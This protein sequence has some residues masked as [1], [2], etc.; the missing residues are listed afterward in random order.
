[1]VNVLLLKNQTVPKDPYNDKL[2]ALGYNPVFIPLL[3]HNHYDRNSTIQYL[4]SKEFSNIRNFIITSQRAVECFNECIQEISDENIKQN[5]FQK[6]GYTVGPA[7]AKILSEA[8]FKNVKGGSDAGNGLILSKIIIDEIDSEEEIVFFTGEIRKDIIP[9]N[10]KLANINITEKVIYKTDLRE[11]IGENFN[12]Q[13][14]LLDETNNNGKQW[15][16]FFSPQGTELIIDKLKLIENLTNDFYI[17]SIGPTTE[18]YLISKGITPNIV[19]KKPE[20]ASLFELM[21]DHET[22]Y[23]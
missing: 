5:I 23:K 15:I 11:D 6:I 9:K 18:D 20:A 22:T 2:K 12:K 19:S 14:S 8:G 10:L 13:L 1:M 3:E 17:G 21:Q 16:I 7:T 4:K